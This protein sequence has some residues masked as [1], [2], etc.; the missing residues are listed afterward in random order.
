VTAAWIARLAGITVGLVAALAPVPA[1]AQ[2]AYPNRP[3]RLIV[4]YSTG[5]P[6]DIFARQLSPKLS[7]QLAWVV[8]RKRAGV[9][10]ASRC[11][12]NGYG[13][14]FDYHVLPSFSGFE[15]V[16]G[17]GYTSIAICRSLVRIDT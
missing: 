16:E 17:M 13:E 9:R 3:L 4:P 2:S 10:Q 6:G 1:Q 7:D 5:G 8:L 15:A 14:N 11:S 12:D